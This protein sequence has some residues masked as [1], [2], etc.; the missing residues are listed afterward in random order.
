M[1]NE[2][3]LRL[4]AME[5]FEKLAYMQVLN[6]LSL[7]AVLARPDLSPSVALKIMDLTLQYGLSL[8]APGGFAVYAVMCIIALGDFDSAF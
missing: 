8:I 6:I 3:I 4:P 2:R 7:N 1:S 5:N